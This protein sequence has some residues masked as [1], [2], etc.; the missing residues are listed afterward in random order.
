MGVSVEI[1][2]ISAKGETAGDGGVQA[3]FSAQ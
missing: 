1:G 3:L 2:G